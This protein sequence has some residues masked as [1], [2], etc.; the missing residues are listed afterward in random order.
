MNMAA[1]NGP[2]RFMS[3]KVEQI[4]AKKNAGV[5]HKREGAEFLVL[6]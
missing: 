6:K 3:I 1:G 5:W 4:V 2:P